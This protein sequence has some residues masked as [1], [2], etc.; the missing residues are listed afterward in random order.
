LTEAVERITR[1][2]TYISREIARDLFEKFCAGSL[3]RS[4][5]PL[6]HLTDRQCEIL[7]LI[8]DGCNTK[9]IAEALGVSPKTVDFHRGKIMQRLNIRDVAGLIRL[10]FREKL[11]DSR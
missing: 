4:E 1:G 6:E 2:E 11:L 8:A 3:P 7:Q 9:Q 5:S 10:A